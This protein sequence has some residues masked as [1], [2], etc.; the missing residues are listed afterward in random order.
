[1]KP[2]EHVSIG[3]YV[4]S[5]EDDACAAAR[6]YLE[7]LGSFYSKVESGAEVMEGIEE[8][9]SELLLEKAG[10]GGVVTLPMVESVM[11]TLGRPEAIEED[12]GNPDKADPEGPKTER[13]EEKVRKKLYR[14]T[15]NGKIAGVCSGLGAYFGI[16]ATLLRLIFVVLTLVGLG[17]FFGRVWF[18]IPE[19]LAPLV[20]FVLWIC[21]PEAKTVSQRDELHGEKGTVDAISARVMSSVQEMGETAERV[22]HSDFWPGIWRVF[23]VCFGIIML[24][25]GVAGVVTLGFLL[26]DGSF[27]S[28]SFFLNRV[29]EDIAENAYTVLD[30]LSYPPF[31]I[32]LAVAVVLPFIGMIY[33][34]VMLIFNLKAPKWHPG[35]CLFVIW[36][37]AI[38]VLAV[39]GAMLLFKGV[40]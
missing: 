5:L 26:F 21:M 9:M 33:G 2:V 40:L 3:G 30:L 12:T 19:C 31:V 24:I 17:V 32:A 23:E 15:A 16:D 38:T 13:K 1:M 34:G 8:R 6:K 20:Y 22:V 35:L 4:F 37:I 27:F 11:A 28:N 18:G 14:D 39:M 10:H 36:L 29:I 25:A 7:E